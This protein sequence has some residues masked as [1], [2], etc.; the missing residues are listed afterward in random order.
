LLKKG[1]VRKNWK[2]R[3]FRLKEKNLFYFETRDPSEKPLGHIDLT[4]YMVKKTPSNT[5]LYG[6]GLFSTQL[7][8]YP[9]CANDEE[10]YI[11]WLTFL[12]LA[13]KGTLKGRNDNDTNSPHRSREVGLVKSYT[14]PSQ[15]GPDGVVQG[16]N[17]SS[18][19]SELRAD[20]GKKHMSMAA[21][22]SKPVVVLR[23]ASEDRDQDDLLQNINPEDD[24]SEIENYISDDDDA[25]DPEE[26]KALQFNLDETKQKTPDLPPKVPVSEE[27][28]EVKKTDS[29]IKI[30]TKSPRVPAR[31][32]EL[33]RKPTKD[34]ANRFSTTGPLNL[35]G[36]MD[37]SDLSK[38]SGKRLTSENY[39]N[40]FE[41]VEPEM[42]PRTV[43]LLM[44]ADRDFAE[45][46]RRSRSLGLMDSII[47]ELSEETIVVPT[48]QNTKTQPESS[49][50]R[51]IRRS[52]V[53][54]PDL[55][56]LKGGNH[57]EITPSELSVIFEE[58]EIEKIK[59]LKE[60]YVV[61]GDPLLKYNIMNK[62]IGKGAVGEV[63][64][65][66]NKENEQKVA[67]KKL[68]LERRG[69]D[70]LPF[71]LRE[72]EIIAT[73]SHENIVGYIESY[74]MGPE[75]W[76]VME[77]M[78]NGSLYDLVKL[79]SRGCKLDENLTAYAIRE[80]TKAVHF[81]HCR[82]RIHRD[83]K[84]DNILI[85]ND[86]SVKLADFGTAVQ[87]TFQRLRRTTLAGTPY[88]M[89]PELIQRIPY[90]EK[91]DVWSIGITVVEIMNGRPPFYELDPREALDA[92][93]IKGVKGLT[94]H[95]QSETIK[96]FVNKQCLCTNPTD[97]A[98]AAQLLSHP[99][100]SNAATKE[101]FAKFLLQSSVMYHLE[102]TGSSGC[103][104]L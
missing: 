32:E 6:F 18:S 101:Q 61:K 103:T 43:D 4:H 31:K 23:S 35:N 92:I 55:L 27:T 96:D 67:I 38:T 30:S 63:F 94:D 58:E 97:R 78:S 42:S 71:I 77:Y 20:G 73:S 91:V 95:K 88:Y 93:V 99:F 53:P 37:K 81:L 13:T 83:I 48:P 86:G 16:R 72:I 60:L 41:I 79:H 57:R 52:I 25:P 102:G 26:R 90:N 22:R 36:L 49:S 75:L 5:R 65:A 8:S 104:I 24:L 44:R 28:T 59:K 89:A 47:E 33:I 45:N 17:R 3:W 15:P 9:L 54:S 87:L 46:N 1:H 14:E 51:A 21:P 50:W 69:K 29:F 19:S 40:E 82:K 62:S 85:K 34:R 64:F 12:K 98:T 68:Q 100:L 74:E 66:T 39:G 11:K 56:S 2:W 84:V 76:V 70:R 80:V 7:P 10:D